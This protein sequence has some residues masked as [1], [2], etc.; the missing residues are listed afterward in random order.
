LPPDM[1]LKGFAKK[2]I[3][4][5]SQR[6]RLPA[7]LL[8]RP[9]Q[10]FN[11]PIS[12]WVLGPLREMCMATLFSPQMLQWFK[13]AEIQRLWDEHERKQRDNGLKLFGLL[14]VGL[15]IGNSGVTLGR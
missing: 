7:W 12:Q 6:N 13:R 11:A 3:L 1:K 2:H 5:H 9:K 14:C 8:D 10:G 15:F 4:R